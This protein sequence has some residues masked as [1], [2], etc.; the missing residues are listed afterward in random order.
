MSF[1]F[2]VLC[3]TALSF[4]YSPPFY[5]PSAIFSKFLHLMIP[6]SLV[7]LDV[8]CFNFTCF[9]NGLRI[10]P[11]LFRWL[12]HHWQIMLFGNISDWLFTHNIPLRADS[13]GCSSSRVL[14]MKI[15]LLNVI[16]IVL[17]WIHLLTF[18]SNTVVCLSQAYTTAGTF[19][20]L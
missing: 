5:P 16:L 10:F 13:W 14:H 2:Y 12:N 18:Q 15:D 8:Q 4:F 9:W 17:F 11:L 20:F 1:E 19:V 6:V 3:A 7:G